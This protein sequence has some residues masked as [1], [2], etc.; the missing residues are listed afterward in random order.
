VGL[1]TGEIESKPSDLPRWSRVLQ[2]EE[3][4]II[5]RKTANPENSSTAKALQ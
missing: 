5:E 1:I 2:D 4:M 3:Q